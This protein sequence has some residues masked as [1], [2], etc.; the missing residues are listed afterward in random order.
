MESLKMKLLISIANL[1]WYIKN[2]LL[3]VKKLDFGKPINN[4][5]HVGTV[6]YIGG[7]R[8]CRNNDGTLEK[9]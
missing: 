4:D 9:F 3:K 6:E 7:Q 1:K 2:R 8:F 5:S